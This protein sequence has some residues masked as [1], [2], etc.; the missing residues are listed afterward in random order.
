[1]HGRVVGAHDALDAA[2]LELAAH[3]VDRSGGQICAVEGPEMPVQVDDRT[4]FRTARVQVLQ[5][6]GGGGTH[7]WT[8]AST[9]ARL[10]WPIASRSV[11]VMSA[12]ARV[13]NAAPLA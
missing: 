2:L 10:P 13:S 12:P 4:A 3:L 11:W 8:S 9:R 6:D 1:G 5:R 7:S